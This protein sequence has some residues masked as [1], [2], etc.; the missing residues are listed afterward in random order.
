MFLSIVTLYF[1][2]RFVDMFGFL[3]YITGGLVMNNKEN[4][5]ATPPVFDFEVN[6][7]K[8]IKKIWAKVRNSKLFKWFRGSRLNPYHW[9]LEDIKA[10]TPEEAKKI[11]R[12]KA[13]EAKK[14]KLKAK[15]EY[16]YNKQRQLAELDCSVDEEFKRDNIVLRG[17]GDVSD[18]IPRNKNGDLDLMAE[19]PIV[20]SI[21]PMEGPA[22]IGHVCMQYKD[23]VVNRLLTSIHTD[24][25]YPKYKE[26]SE[27]YFVYPS[28]LGID[29]KK[30][31]REMDKQ[32]IRKYNK[33][34]NLISNNCARNVGQVLKKVGV[35]DIDFM[36]FDDIGL[37]FTN[38][39]NNPFG[40]GI[41]AWC[42]KHGVHVNLKE[43]E[44]YHERHNFTDV[45]ERRAKMKR[46]R[47]KYDAYKRYV[48]R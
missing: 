23:R 45:K 25:L 22:L 30:L 44:K 8:G 21:V 3:G 46:I 36:G 31:L 10:K 34:Y 28:K 13:I 4:N 47:A 7:F 40:N 11:A 16:I 27:Y 33:K 17:K 39:G 2:V 43:M 12:K 24:P 9:G 15:A 26:Y 42:L 18:R 6:A 29:G 5:M 38:P 48:G 41:R 37:V 20:I 32:N 19:D 1:F 35:D 14:K